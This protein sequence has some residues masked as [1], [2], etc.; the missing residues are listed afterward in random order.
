MILRLVKGERDRSRIT[1]VTSDREVAQE[2]KRMGAR[3][4]GSAE[5][6]GGLGRGGD[7][8]VSGRRKTPPGKGPLARGARRSA[9]GEN[10][11]PTYPTADEVNRWERIFRDGSPEDD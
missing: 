1:V 10:E 4:M 3:V 2:A 8:G 7:R 5:Y 11:K 9:P 6:A